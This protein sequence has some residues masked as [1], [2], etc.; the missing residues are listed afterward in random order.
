MDQVLL[1]E[2][3]YRYFSSNWR[4]VTWKEISLWRKMKLPLLSPELSI[5]MLQRYQLYDAH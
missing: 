5:F 1:I 3:R 2:L 4:V